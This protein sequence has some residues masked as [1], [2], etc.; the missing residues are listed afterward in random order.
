MKLSKNG[1]QGVIT[2]GILVIIFVSLSI[3][4]DSFL[5]YTNINNVLQQTTP[6]I[7]TGVAAT[8]LMISGG[9]DLSVGSVVALSGVIMARAAQ[10]DLPMSVAI[11]SGVIVGLLIGCTNGLLVDRLRIPPVIVTMG[12]MYIARALALIFSDGKAINVGLPKNYTEIGRGMIGGLS[13]PVIIMILMVLLF[14]FIEKRTVMGKYSF[15]IGGNRAASIYSGVNVHMLTVVY[16]AVT[17]LLAGFS[18]CILGS[19]LG[20]GSPNVGDGFEFDVVVAVV[21]GGT[22]MSGGEGSVA[23]TLIGA[24]IIGFLGNGLNL[25]GV[26]S[27]YQGLLKGVVLVLA[28]ILDTAIRNRLAGKRVS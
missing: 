21:L 24:L 4:T 17:G 18:G 5:S 9:I 27:F 28:V 25:M 16:Y 20:V 11:L 6:T 15:A 10:A 23:G 7:I 22:S 13:V 8:L 19:R 3:M 14:I 26:E 12:S 1:L 2:L